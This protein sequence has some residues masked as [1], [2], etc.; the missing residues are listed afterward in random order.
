MGCELDGCFG[1]LC[2]DAILDMYGLYM[3]VSV[4]VA[5]LF[6]HCDDVE[7]QAGEVCML[8][9]G[10]LSTSKPSRSGRKFYILGM[11]KTSLNGT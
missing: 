5:G 6:H 2:R 11:N 7:L 8:Q 10:I 4:Y 9:H 1:L 3:Y